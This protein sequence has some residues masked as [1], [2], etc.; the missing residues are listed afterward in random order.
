[1]SAKDYENIY[2]AALVDKIKKWTESSR[3]T[4]VGPNE[5]S[6]LF[7]VIADNNGDKPIELPLIA[8]SRS[9]GFSIINSGT[10]KRP[11]SY[12]GVT[13]EVTSFEDERGKHS[14]STVINAIPISISYQLDV[15]TR[16][17]IEA[18][19]LVRNLIFNIINYPGM[20]I[21]IPKTEEKHTATIRLNDTVEDNSDIKEQFIK[22][23]FTR[24][25]LI[26]SVEDA[27]LWDVRELHNMEIDIIID[28]LMD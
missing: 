13:Y 27:Y 2:D 3:L 10:T 12:D 11:L 21:T 4:V 20:E 17:A 18:D 22:G 24:L 6:R 19:I 8:I 5:T 26:L 9:R 16:Y 14:K 28:D 25:S 15:Y 7:E 1:M 23:N